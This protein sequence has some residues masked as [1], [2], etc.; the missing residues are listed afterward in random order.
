MKIINH[1]KLKQASEQV[2][3]EAVK[4]RGIAIQCIKNPSEQVQL[5][6]V[7]QDGEA[8][9]HIKNP[10]EQVKLAAFESYRRTIT[11]YSRD[12][13][14][15]DCSTKSFEEWKNMTNREI[16]RLGFKLD[17]IAKPM[18]IKAIEKEVEEN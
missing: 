1:V 10:S 16:L 4:Q 13:I 11:I 2:Q 8:I 9:E 14:K 3:L 6:A 18:L 15:I 17:V 7:K 12:E 5:A